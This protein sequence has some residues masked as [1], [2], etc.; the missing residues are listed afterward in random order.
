[1]KKL[2]ITLIFSLGIIG[3]LFT[4]CFCKEVQP[5]WKPTTGSTMMQAISNTGYTEILANDTIEAD[6]IEIGIFFEAQYISQNNNS[7]MSQLGN[8]ARATQKCPTDGHQGLKYQVSE[9]TIVSDQDFG[10]F[11][12]GDDLKSQ[13]TFRGMP[14]SI[15]YQSIFSN[16][17]LIYDQKYGDNIMLKNQPNVTVERT[18]TIT[19]EFQDGQVIQ[20]TTLP[21]TW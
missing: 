16:N 18:F 13:F 11:S 9:L 5:Y 21:F 10:Q 2:S 15:N 6:S 20:M 1:M 17:H 4:A 8:V 14:L 3:A 12:A 19:V 7:W